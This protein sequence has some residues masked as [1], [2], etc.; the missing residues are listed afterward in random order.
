MSSRVRSAFI[1]AAT[2]LALRSGG[3]AA[4]I[5]DLRALSAALDAFPR[6]QPDDEIGA[7]HGHARAM[8]SARRYGDEVGYSEAH[9]ALRLEMAA[10]WA[11][12]AGAFSKGG[13]A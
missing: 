9:Y 13:E 4:C 10:H 3:I 2:A 7:A 1:I 12:W 6:A 5:G 8:M 11:R